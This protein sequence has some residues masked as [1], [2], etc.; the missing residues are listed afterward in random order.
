MDHRYIVRLEGPWFLSVQLRGVARTGTF[1]KY[2]MS[3]GTQVRFGNGEVCEI[4]SQL[5]DGGFDF[6]ELGGGRG[7]GIVWKR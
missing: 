4:G 2:P 3:T 1:T 5:V 6:G 7:F